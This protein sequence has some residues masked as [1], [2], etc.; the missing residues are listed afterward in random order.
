M[1]RR[2]GLDGRKREVFVLDDYDWLRMQGAG[3]DRVLIRSL[4]E[5]Q[6]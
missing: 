6:C 5:L 3:A 4:G 1:S 2:T